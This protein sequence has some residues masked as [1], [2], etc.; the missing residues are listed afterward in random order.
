MLSTFVGKTF[1]AGLEYLFVIENIL[2]ETIFFRVAIARR[3]AIANSRGIS[4]CQTSGYSKYSGKVPLPDVLPQ[5]IICE[6]S[7]ARR[8]LQDLCRKFVCVE[9]LRP[10]Q[11]SGVMSSAVSFA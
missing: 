11:P 6:Y 10:S 7:A 8:V 4:Y 2:S 1:L 9:V 3:L 5:Q